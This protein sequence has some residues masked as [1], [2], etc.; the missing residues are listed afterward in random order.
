MHTRLSVSHKRE[1]DVLPAADLCTDWMH[2]AIREER[3][4]AGDLSRAIESVARFFGVTERR[5]KSYWWKRV[6]HVPADEM[7]RIASRRAER[8]RL[9]RARAEHAIAMADV[10][11][12][13]ADALLASMSGAQDGT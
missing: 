11:I 3:A 4:R 9:E 12:A 13:A 7:M 5:A 1:P 6:T 8:V 10:E 2:Q